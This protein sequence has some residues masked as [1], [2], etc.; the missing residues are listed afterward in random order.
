VPT[1]L[2]AGD[3]DAFFSIEA[4]REVAAAIRG[5]RLEV[6]AGAGHSPYW[7]EPDAFCARVEAFLE[8]VGPWESAR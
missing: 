2:L 4:L 3:E 7:E 1:L 6:I 8:E 5:A